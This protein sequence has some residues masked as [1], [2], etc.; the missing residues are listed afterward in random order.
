MSKEKT[1]RVSNQVEVREGDLVEAKRNVQVRD[2]GGK[3]VG[4][5]A[6]GT[7]VRIDALFVEDPGPCRSDRGRLGLDG[8]PH[9]DFNPRRFRKVTEI[10]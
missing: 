7:V 1:I 5:I 9:S 2:D 10:S 4:Q 8:Y 6:R 3:L